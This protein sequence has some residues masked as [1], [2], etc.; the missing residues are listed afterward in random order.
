MGLTKDYD[1]TPPY[2]LDKADVVSDVLSRK[3]VITKKL[4]KQYKKH[5]S[6]LALIG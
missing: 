2:N 6:K 1:F 5:K 3:P 4:K